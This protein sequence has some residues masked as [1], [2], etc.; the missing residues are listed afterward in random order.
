[1]NIGAAFSAIFQDR[2]W[3]TKVVITGIIAFF[4]GITAPLLIGLVGSVILLGYQVEIVRRVR[5]DNAAVLPLWQDFGT[6][7]SEGAAALLAYIAYIFP[8][9]LMAFF[10]LIGASL[11]GN[12]GAG[13]VIILCIACL[14][15][16][17]ILIY[18]FVVSAMHALAMG[19]YAEERRAGVFFQFQTLFALVVANGGATFQFVINLFLVSLIVGLIALIPCIG[20][21]IAPSLGFLLSAILAGQYADV[22]LDG[23]EKP[24]RGV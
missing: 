16:P 6:L 12:G 3:A 7:L 5:E 22:V 24:K 18:F 9:L 11:F 17:L 4:S 15:L 21:V 10:A 14:I 8:A 13:S 1:M 19:M 23:G 2:D 20:W